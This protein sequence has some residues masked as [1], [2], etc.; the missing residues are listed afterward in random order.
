MNNASKPPYMSIVGA[1]IFVVAVA[2]LVWITQV[3][4]KVAASAAQ[5]ETRHSAAA[6]VK[7]KDAA[8]DKVAYEMSGDAAHGEELFAGT[9]SACHAPDGT[10]I[11]GLG[12]NLT[13]SE[14]SAG[15]TDAQLL[16]FIKVGRSTSD[17][18]N[19]TGIDMP[20]KGGNPAL[21]D[22]DLNDIVTFLRTIHTN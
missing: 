4:P 3:Q 15:Q 13:T 22:E 8:Q 14:F 6:D 21:S 20:P 11:E 9:C 18:L 16:A 17:S 7:A 5:E 19:T 10:G 2:F 1:L 12:K